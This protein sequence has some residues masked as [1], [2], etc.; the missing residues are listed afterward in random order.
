ML[1]DVKSLVY[2]GLDAVGTSIWQALQKCPNAADAFDH[3][4][5]N[6]ELDVALL[7]TKFDGVLKGLE[8][9]KIVELRPI[10]E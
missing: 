3:V 9:S 10:G 4:A 2:Y 5:A 8:A 1:L 7:A 6:S